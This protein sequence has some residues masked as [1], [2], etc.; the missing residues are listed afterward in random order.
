M[1]SDDTYLV[2]TDDIQS[3][4]SGSDRERPS[5]VTV[6]F[7]KLKKTHLTKWLS[8]RGQSCSRSESSLCF[9]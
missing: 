2:G 9:P 7:G 6:G 8:T 4:D 3:N 1:S 5:L